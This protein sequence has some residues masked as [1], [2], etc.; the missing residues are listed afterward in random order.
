MATRKRRQFQD[1]F[2]EVLTGSVTVDIAS[3]A[4]GAR[5]VSGN[6]TIPGLAIG[7][8]FLGYSTNGV[9]P[10]NVIPVGQVTAADTAVLAF[11]NNTAGAVDPASATYTVVFGKLNADLA[12]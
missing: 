1:C 3:I 9:N 2:S 12:V 5:G 8:V 11:E 10:G 7:D 4:A 6:I